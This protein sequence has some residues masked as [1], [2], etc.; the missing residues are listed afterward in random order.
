[1]EVAWLP[2]SLQIIITKILNH[3]KYYADL[4]SAHITVVVF[5]LDFHKIK[6]QTTSPVCIYP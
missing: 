6:A 5:D 4:L 3:S 1:M 2:V